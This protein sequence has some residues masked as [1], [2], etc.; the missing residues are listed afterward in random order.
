MSSF[1]WDVDGEMVD[2]VFSLIRNAEWLNEDTKDAIVFEYL[3]HP[4]ICVMQVDLDM[5]NDRER[6]IWEMLLQVS[7]LDAT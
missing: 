5:D 3:D 1:K 7:G 4:Y 2:I 6:E